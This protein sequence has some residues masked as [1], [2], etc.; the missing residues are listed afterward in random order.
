MGY[1]S[2]KWYPFLDDSHDEII[3]QSTIQLAHNLGLKVTAEGV[4]DADEAEL[5]RS[6]GCNTIQGYYFGRPMPS[7]EV[8]QIFTREKQIRARA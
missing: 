3:V 5:I 8:R 6:L 2:D 7:G 1:W 4:E